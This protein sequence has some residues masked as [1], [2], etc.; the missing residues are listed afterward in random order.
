MMDICLGYYEI[1][2]QR[3]KIRLK[4]DLLDINILNNYKCKYVFYQIIV[5]P[6]I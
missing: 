3:Q 5:D 6:F 2:I 4:I 1:R